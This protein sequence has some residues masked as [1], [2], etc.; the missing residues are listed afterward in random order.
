VRQ[1][2]AW[3]QDLIVASTTIT[4]EVASLVLDDPAELLPANFGFLRMRKAVRVALAPG[5]VV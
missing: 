5:I 3:S 1:Q 2:L 4:K